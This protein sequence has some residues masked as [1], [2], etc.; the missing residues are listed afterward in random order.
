M[1]YAIRSLNFILDR[2]VVLIPFVAF[3]TMGIMTPYTDTFAAYMTNM[4][5]SIR[6][7]IFSFPPRGEWASP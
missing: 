6:H 4:R 2:P 5:M 3:S 7:I 1:Q